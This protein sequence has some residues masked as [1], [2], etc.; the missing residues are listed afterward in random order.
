MR[1][2]FRAW[3]G[4]IDGCPRSLDDPMQTQPSQ[5]IAHLAL[6]DLVLGNPEALRK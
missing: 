5:I 2:S 6:G 3:S 1:F 4:G